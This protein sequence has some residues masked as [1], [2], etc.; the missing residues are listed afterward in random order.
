MKPKIL[1]DKEI[2]Q[3]AL[4]YNILSDELIFDLI[5]LFNSQKPE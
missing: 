1:E 3:V 4:I 5:E 2:I